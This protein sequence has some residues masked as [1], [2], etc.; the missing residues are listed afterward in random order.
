MFFSSL[1]LEGAVANPSENKAAKISTMQK[2]FL[3]I[4]GTLAALVAGIAFPDLQCMTDF[5]GTCCS[6]TVICKD[7]DCKVIEKV[8]EC[9]ERAYP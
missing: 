1:Q 9:I 7:N 6:G 4:F 3:L 5:K 2:T 8:I